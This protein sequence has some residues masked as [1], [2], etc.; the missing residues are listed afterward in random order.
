MPN[1]FYE[2]GILGIFKNNFCPRF[3]VIS[4]KGHHLKSFPGNAVFVPEMQSLKK[5]GHHLKSFLG[6]AVFVLKIQ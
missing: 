5:K 6:N 4:K 3:K 1:Q 2:L